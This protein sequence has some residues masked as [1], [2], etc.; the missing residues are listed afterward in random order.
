MKDNRSS[1]NGKPDEFDGMKEAFPVFWN[2]FRSL[3]TVKGLKPAP[4]KEFE[5]K[6]PKTEMTSR[7]MAKQKKAAKNNTMVMGYIEM[8]MTSAQ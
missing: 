1:I 5:A 2:K 4:L 6:L 8:E 3:M 7:Q